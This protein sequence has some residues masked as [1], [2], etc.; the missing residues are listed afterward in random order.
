MI[1]QTHLEEVCKLGQGEATC[2]FLMSRGGM[3]MECAKETEIEP[4][5]RQRLFLGTMN[6]KG[7]NCS[8]WSNLKVEE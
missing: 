1:T 3:D 7:D 8:G 6:A 5:I 4:V 2:A